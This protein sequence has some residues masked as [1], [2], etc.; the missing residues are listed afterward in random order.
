MTVVTTTARLAA[1]Y[2]Q[3]AGMKTAFDTFPR[4]LQPVECPAAVIWPAEATYDTDLLGDDD[5]LETRVYRVTV[6]YGQSLFGSE[7]QQQTGIIALIDAIRDTFVARPGLELTGSTVIVADQ[8]L[9]GDSGIQLTQYPTG[10]ETASDF[11]AIEFRHQIQ[12]VAA[13]AY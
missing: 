4:V 7:G 5:V 3:I 12:E 6:F 10:K 2:R 9:L 13:I 1:L 11:W 8:R